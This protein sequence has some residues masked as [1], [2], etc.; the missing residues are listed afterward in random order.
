MR[1]GALPGINTPELTAAAGG[2]G[3]AEPAVRAHQLAVVEELA[4][5]G[6]G[7]ELVKTPTQNPMPRERHHFVC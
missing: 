3:F 2:D 4:G 5:Y 6:D 1:M 7:V